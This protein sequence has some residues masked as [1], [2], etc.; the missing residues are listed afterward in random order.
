MIAFIIIGLHLALLIMM[1][2]AA[3]LLIGAIVRYIKENISEI[4]SGMRTN[5]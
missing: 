4:L 2:G 5:E 1:Y 3:S